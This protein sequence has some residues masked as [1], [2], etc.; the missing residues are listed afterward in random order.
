MQDMQ[1]QRPNF[2][3]EEN[4]ELKY[5]DNEVEQINAKNSTS[6]FLDSLPER[7]NHHPGSSLGQHQLSKPPSRSK[8]LN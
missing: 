7:Y 6:N 1:N 2:I 8:L 3:F 4:E 5:M